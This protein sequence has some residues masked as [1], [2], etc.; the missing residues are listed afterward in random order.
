MFDVFG[1]CTIPIYNSTKA[2]PAVPSSLS[3]T[4]QATTGQA[5]GSCH[6]VRSLLLVR[7]RFQEGAETSVQLGGAAACLSV[8]S[9]INNNKNNLLG[10]LFKM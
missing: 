4:G 10:F 5:S 6:V 9:T 7:I 1:P 8:A 3:G 2:E